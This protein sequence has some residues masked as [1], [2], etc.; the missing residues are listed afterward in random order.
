[1][2]KFLTRQYWLVAL[3]MCAVTSAQTQVLLP[4]DMPPE[5]RQSLQKSTAELNAILDERGVT[6]Q[7]T[8]ELEI[9]VE[10]IRKD[11]AA[12]T[13]AL[14]QSAKTEKKLAADIF[15]LQ[16]DLLALETQKADIQ[17]GLW[18]RRGALAE[19]LAAL[20]RMG[21]NPPPAI[22]VTPEDALGSVR[23]SILLS[24]VVPHMR[25]ETEILIADIQ[26]LDQITGSITSEQ[27]KLKSTRQEQAAEQKR[28]TLLVEEKRKIEGQTAAELAAQQKR[29]AELL[30]QAESMESFISSLEDE[31]ERVK[32]EAEEKLRAEEQARIE[33]EQ[34]K[35][36]EAEAARLAAEK[37]REDAER[38][39]READEAQ[40]LAA[41]QK[42][43][44]AE[45]ARLNAEREQRE[46]QL[47][48]NAAR[49]R[50]AELAA[51]PSSIAPAAAFSTRSGQLAKPVS[52][53]T[54]TA[55]GDDD[56]LGQRAQGDTLETSP[57]A[58]VTAPADGKVLYA[59]PFRAYG[60][61]LIIDAGEE[62]HLVLAGMDR[63]DVAQG[64]FV[65]EG[66]PVGAMGRIR[67]ASVTAA[68][69]KNDNPTLY[70]EFRKNSKPID[71]S[72]WWEK[73]SAGRT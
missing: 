3:F 61:L 60:N 42:L 49:E 44:E 66:E 51:K 12:I 1:M 31:A 63:I 17:I 65:L 20:Q 45:T 57:N 13:A 18:E 10:A 4:D 16:E 19:V 62:Y 70:I 37:A 6:E 7:R 40:Q 5:V 58:I 32:R 41:E 38:A 50:A 22:L 54:I 9:E 24:A 8:K 69:T 73:I 36:A 71:P 27:E 53:R 34:R 59:G 64:Q 23:S 47:R 30:A 56:G 68:A 35:K 43:R 29:M 11:R 52:G 48:I 21:L 55:F 26:E 46:A 2:G 72:P 28:L 39:K 33:E 25:A 14:I 67:L 15:Q